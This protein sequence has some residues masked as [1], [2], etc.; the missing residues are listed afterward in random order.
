[1]KLTIG[2]IV[3]NEEKWLEKCLTAI[4]PILDNVD[5][6]LIITDTGSTD[7]TVEIAKKFTDKVLYFEWINDFAAARNY[8]LQ[9]AHG[10]WFMF[11]DADNIFETCNE[12]I[13]FFNSD[14][15]KKYNSATHIIRNYFRNDDRSEF[16]DEIGTRLT[17]ILP[18]TKFVG[19]VH[20]S[21]STLG[22]P[23]KDLSDIAEHYG[24]VSD[25]ENLETEKKKRNEDILLKELENSGDEKRKAHV[26]L[27]LHESLRV[28]AR[29]EAEKYLDQ[30]IAL[31]EKI[32]SVYL[33][34]ML[35]DKIM[36]VFQRKQYDEVVR[37][38]DQY[39]ALG[40]DIRSGEL[41]SDAE[42]YA[43]KAESFFRMDE[44]PK[45]VDAFE[46]YLRVYYLNVEGK[47]L[48]SE[49]YIFQPVFSGESNYANMLLDAVI[50][51][52]RINEHDR[53]K[54]YIAAA[55][56]DKMA[57]GSGAMNGLV[58]I[59]LQLMGMRDFADAQI[60]YN[61]L[62]DSGKTLFIN[63][64]ANLLYFEERK[65]N[66]VHAF[67]TI[68]KGD[69]WLTGLTNIYEMFVRGVIDDNKVLE[70][71][72]KYG[73]KKNYDIVYIL[74]CNGSDISS[75]LL[76]DDFDVEAVA[77]RCCDKIYK[78]YET[79]GDYITQYLT[80]IESYPQMADFLEAIIKKAIVA[81]VPLSKIIQRYIDIGKEYAIRG[82]AAE[83][84][85][86]IYGAVILSGI[87]QLRITKKYKECFAE[88]KNAIEQYPVIAPI[89]G[90]YKDIITGE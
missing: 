57:S 4:K 46:N 81:K 53:A 18:E 16:S 9:E 26:Y 17:K 85:V 62:N 80:N 51:A 33:I 47:L 23:I 70:F 7:R 28:S 65:L 67:E 88:M 30:G 41:C 22:Y 44:F 37:I 25:D 84:P 90:Q 64:L 29:E 27:L 21:L 48:T 34:P 63:S 1:M 15:Y 54:R 61:A 86:Q 39:F 72:D 31:A 83:M 38:C 35:Q 42:F 56:P 60:Y 11:L 74:M 12:I 55:R 77:E 82:N 19:A 45:A 78:F 32:R 59:E 73:L 3:K 50:S 10:E 75:L 6:E 52:I 76:R 24:Y 79:V 68:C 14:E 43:A 71:V 13:D 58:D 66:I 89:I 20:E 5:C 87:D 49:R 8:G 2:M 36:V 69:E 40:K